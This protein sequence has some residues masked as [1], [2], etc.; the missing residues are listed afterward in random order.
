MKYLKTPSNQRENYVYR[1]DDG[2]K[3]V[4][5]SGEAMDKWIK[6][7]HSL[8]DAEVYNNIK[9]NSDPYRRGESKGQEE[10]SV[11][12][13]DTKW[14]LSIDSLITDDFDKSVCAFKLATPDED[15][16][17]DMV[18]EKVMK[19]SVLQREIFDLYFLE[20]YSQAEIATLKQVSQCVISRNISRIKK[21]LKKSFQKN[22]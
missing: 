6:M 4:I 3:V 5:E 14:S 10:D 17:R 7:L 18:Y 9:N 12:E 21:Y 20:G 1:F 19:L 2:S 8:D 11:N 15:P 22:S 13:S 16:I